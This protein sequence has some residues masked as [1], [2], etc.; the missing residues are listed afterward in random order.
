MNFAI[1]FIEADREYFQEKG[2]KE[3]YLLEEI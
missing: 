3:G 1:D 2:R